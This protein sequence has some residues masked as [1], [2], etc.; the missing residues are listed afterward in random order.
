MRAVIDTNVILVANGAH[1]E[2]SEDCRATCFERLARMARRGRCVIDEGY[3][4]LEEYLRKTEPHTSRRAGDV[5][6]KWLLNNQHNPARVERV[7]ITPSS[8]RTYAEL[9]KLGLSVTIDP[10]DRK[11]IAVAA[12]RRRKPPIWQAA[13][14]KWLDWWES[15]R[16]V[17]ITV[18]FLC[19]DDLI[20]H[21]RR[22]FPKRGAP[23]L[24]ERHAFSARRPPRA[25]R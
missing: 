19:P 7:P 13:D 18:E 2:T 4:I 16:D 20:R 22:K 11:F 12:G 24:P 5:F 1:A 15:L 14:S 21:Y 23:T 25:S 9:D 3:E 10:S 17:G 6:L 8:S